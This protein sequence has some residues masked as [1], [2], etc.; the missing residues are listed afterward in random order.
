MRPRSRDRYRIVCEKR[1]VKTSV[2]GHKSW[3]AIPEGKGMESCQTLLF[4]KSSYEFSIVLWVSENVGRRI[5]AM[6][7]VG[8]RDR[9]MK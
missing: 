7:V 1:I 3:R 9:V 4:A 6:N 8:L 2:G 5:E